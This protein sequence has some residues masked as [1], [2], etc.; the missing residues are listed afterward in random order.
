MATF[1]K[2]GT[3]FGKLGNKFVVLSP[4]IIDYGFKLQLTLTGATPSVTI[5]MLGGYTYNYNVTWGDGS[6]NTVTSSVIR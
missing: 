3:K 6:G 4:P 5:P 2:L 1:A